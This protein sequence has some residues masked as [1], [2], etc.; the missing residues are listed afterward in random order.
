MTARFLVMSD[1]HFDASGTDQDYFWW[2][3][4][5]FT[6]SDEIAESLV[7]TVRDLA[8]DFIIHCGDFTTAS[9]LESFRFGKEVMDRM[10][11][12]Y[13]ITL[14][15]HDTFRP[16]VREAIL[17]L[18]ENSGR[19]FY[20]A[21]DLG[22]LRF[23]FL[24]GQSSDC[25][26]RDG[27]FIGI[28]PLREGL[29]WLEEELQ[30]TDGKPAVFVTHPPLFWKPAYP[31]GSLPQGKPVPESPMPTGKFLDPFV[32]H[33]DLARI[34]AS[35]ANVKAA[36]AGHWHIVDLVVQD[37]VVCCQAPSLIEFPLEMRLVELDGQRLSIRTV[38][39]RDGS[40]RRASIVEEWKNEWVAG[41]PDDREWS[42]EIS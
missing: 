39:L 23:F 28:G 6:M 21:R 15:N 9:D 2:N 11:C 29:E 31:I 32:H 17:P 14:G 16:G 34:A 35:S 41:G 5:L 19:D 36:F 8:P 18:F 38:G 12:P 13:Y 1:T 40:F 33:G 30:D 4:M 24:D 26:P 10:D 25:M 3:R 22:G 20:Y 37:G 42:G 7:E 27:G